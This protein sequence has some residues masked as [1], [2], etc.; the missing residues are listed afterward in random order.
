MRHEEKQYISN[1]KVNVLKFFAY[2]NTTAIELLEPSNNQSIVKK[3]LNKKGQGI[4]HIAL[5]VDNLNNAIKYLKYKQITL[6]YDEPQIGSDKKLI[7]FIHPKSSP[8]MLIEL[9]QKA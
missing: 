5:T 6:V 3:Y 4:H 9:C 1:E 2:D 7:T 8:G